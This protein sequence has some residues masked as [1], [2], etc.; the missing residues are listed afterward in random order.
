MFEVQHVC[1]GHFLETEARRL[2][3]GGLLDTAKAHNAADGMLSGSHPRRLAA[4]NLVAS[5]L[6]I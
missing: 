4:K 2:S 5:A 6:Q 1:R 3:A